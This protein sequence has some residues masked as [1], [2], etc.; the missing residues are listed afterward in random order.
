MNQTT[1][2]TE[3]VDEPKRRV[4][5]RGLIINDK[6]QIFAV[7][8]R[9]K[10]GDPAKHWSTPGGGLDIGE[11]IITGLRREFI[12]EMAVEPKIGNLLYVHQFNNRFG[13]EQVEFIFHIENW[14]DFTNV[15]LSKTTHG[16][17]EITEYGFIDT[18]DY[19]LMPAFLSTVDFS[20][21]LPQNVEIHSYL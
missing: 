19:E 7:K 14:Q 1:S 15:D 12:E 11:E 9:R 6:G 10:S 20:K 8:H 13:F 4:A 3:L 5:V 2:K 18:K 17:V 21:P 16:L